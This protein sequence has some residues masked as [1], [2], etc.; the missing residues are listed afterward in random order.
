MNKRD[1][2]IRL[3]GELLYVERRLADEVLRDLHAAA[4]DGELRGMLEAH[5]AETKEHAERVETAFRRMQVAPTSNRSRVFESAVAEH[6]DTALSIG[7]P[8][9]EDIFH[10]QAALHTELWEIA[11]YRVLLELL[12]DDAAEV[13]QPSLEDEQHAA[14]LLETAIARLVDAG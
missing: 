13:I 5:R 8:R 1:L 6:A 9:L 10:A 14:R 3:L 4:H 2:T 11:S 7:N 12:P